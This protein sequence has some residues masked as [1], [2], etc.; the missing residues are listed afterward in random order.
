[1]S[2]HCPHKDVCGSCS[3]SHIPYEKQLKQKLSDI[4]GS[5]GLKKLPPWCETFLP[6]PITEHYRNR[7]DFV[8]DFEGRVGMR[9]KGKWWRVV[10]GNSCFLADKQID[11]L[12]VKVREW[13]KQNGLSFYDRKAHTGLL[14][15]AVIRST[16]LGQTMV[17]L[18]TSSPRHCEEQRDEANQKIAALASLTRNDERSTFIW[19]QNSTITD[20]SFG[21]KLETIS[22][23]GYIEEEI[24]GHRYRISPNAF[25]QTNPHGAS[26]LLQTVEEFCGDLSSKTLLDLYCGSG[27]FSVALARKA[28]RTVGLEMVNEAIVDARVN[29]QINNVKVTY[30]DAK[31]EEYDWAQ[32]GADVVILDPP[33]SGMH[34]KTLADILKNPPKEI[35]YISCNYKNFA[36]EMVELHKHYRVDAMRAI[37]LFPHTPHVELVTKLTR[38]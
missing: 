23:S 30:H 21:D 6:S 10:D 26:N 4:N 7:M 9:E 24:L 11:A 28:S 33:R 29:A 22:G 20:V 32:F 31:A 1:M 12:F 3:W 36:R 14:R 16:T 37:D 27:F 25:F 34:D 38:I 8:I 15:Y 13:V 5:F 2:S 18:V 19:S 17:N 35:V